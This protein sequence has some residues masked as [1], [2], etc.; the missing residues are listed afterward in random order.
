MVASAEG[1]PTFE[2]EVDSLGDETGVELATGVGVDD[3]VGVAVGPGVEGADGVEL[4]VAVG[5][6]DTVGVAVGVA[7]GVGVAL[8]VAV[9]V[10]VGVELTDGV[11]LAVGV[12]VTTAAHWSF[13]KVLVSRVTAPFRASSEP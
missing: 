7:V 13:T 5:V 4:A 10:T 6:D 2:P 8:T 9:G 12:G 11:T 3:T 1:G